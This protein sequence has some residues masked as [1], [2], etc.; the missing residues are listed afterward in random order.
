MNKDLLTHITSTPQPTQEQPVN[1]TVNPFQPNIKQEK[2]KQ[3][4]EVVKKS[5]IRFPKSKTKSGTLFEPS[6]LDETMSH[7]SAMSQEHRPEPNSDNEEQI[8][9]KKKKRKQKQDIIL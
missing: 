1:V 9:E 7:A 4:K 8:K 6:G 2:I 3:E 5:V